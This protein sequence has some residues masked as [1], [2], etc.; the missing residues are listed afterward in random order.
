MPLRPTI[1]NSDGL[2][3][4]N[5]AYAHALYL[6]RFDGEV[7]CLCFWNWQSGFRYLIHVCIRGLAAADTAMSTCV[8]R[9]CL[10]PVSNPCVADMLSGDWGQDATQ[11]PSPLLVGLRW[12]GKASFCTMDPTF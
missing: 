8:K 12:L 9:A 7:L 6:A 10:D 5:L 3:A 4:H 11:S 2:Q 1:D